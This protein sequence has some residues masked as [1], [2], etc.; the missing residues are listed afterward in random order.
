M[1]KTLAANRNEKAARLRLVQTV[2]QSKELSRRKVMR[3]TCCC[4]LRSYGLAHDIARVDSVGRIQ[5]N[6]STNPVYFF[7]ELGCEL[8]NTNDFNQRCKPSSDFFRRLPRNTIVATKG[9]SISDD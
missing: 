4:E 8:V 5:K 9:V 2:A 7:S 6:H 1:V 3:K